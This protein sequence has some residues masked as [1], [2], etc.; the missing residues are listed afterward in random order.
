M[1]RYSIPVIIEVKCQF[2]QDISKIDEK[3]E[4]QELK[5]RSTLENGT[6]AIAPVAPLA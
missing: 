4:K 5:R 2:L 6:R 1:T 3:Q